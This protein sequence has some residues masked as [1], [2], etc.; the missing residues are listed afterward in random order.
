MFKIYNQSIHH[1]PLRVKT[2]MDF[3]LYNLLIIKLKELNVTLE[4]RGRDDLE[5]LMN[6]G[7][8]LFTLF[9]DLNTLVITNMSMFAEDF[10]IFSS[11]SV[12]K[13][14]YLFVYFIYR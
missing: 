12:Y 14:S 5:R 9:I 6:L 1:F 3:F 2:I 8:L 7:L 11:I 4:V 13:Y 10:K